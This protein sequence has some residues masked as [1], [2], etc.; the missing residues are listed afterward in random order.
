LAGTKVETHNLH[1]DTIVN[2]L[3]HQVETTEQQEMALVCI[4]EGLFTPVTTNT[5]DTAQIETDATHQ[6]A[7]IQTITDLED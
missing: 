3:A 4:K 1:T 5:E 2:P 7:G 6:V